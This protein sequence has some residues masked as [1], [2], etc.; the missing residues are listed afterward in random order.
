MPG[1]GSPD[2]EGG[3]GGG[4]SS[5]AVTAQANAGLVT[6][7]V[8]GVVSLYNELPVAEVKL[9]D[10]ETFETGASWKEPKKV[11]TDEELRVLFP[12]EYTHARIK[13]VV[14]FRTHDLLAFAW[15]GAPDDKLT[16]TVA[17]QA[18]KFGLAPGDAQDQP[19]VQHRKL[20]AVRR[21]VTWSV[22]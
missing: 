4:A 7:A 14:D 2:G 18:A 3:F 12:D 22:D 13:T 6:L 8:Y 1:G 10:D 20:F 11:S 5:P 19:K 9:D 17:E 15:E 16:F 21:T